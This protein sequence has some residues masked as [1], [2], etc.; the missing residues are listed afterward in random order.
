MSPQ[1]ALGTG[2]GLIE[3]CVLSTGALTPGRQVGKR[4]RDREERIPASH[5]VSRLRVKKVLIYPNRRAI[6][7]GYFQFGVLNK[8]PVFKQKASLAFQHCY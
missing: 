6:M 2:G 7:C 1:L 5:F 4:G 8:R 3:V